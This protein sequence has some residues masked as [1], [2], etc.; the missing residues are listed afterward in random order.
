MKLFDK[1]KAALVPGTTHGLD[2]YDVID[3]DLFEDGD[4]AD[5]PEE[6]VNN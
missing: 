3:P 6:G 2:E 1:I 5:L 4:P